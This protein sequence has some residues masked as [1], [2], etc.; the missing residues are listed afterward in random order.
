[1]AGLSIN[2]KHR[3]LMGGISIVREL[4]GNAR[5]T[6]CLIARRKTDNKKVLTTN[7]P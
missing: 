3:S 7:P 1:M 4:G 5:V 2:D 6:S